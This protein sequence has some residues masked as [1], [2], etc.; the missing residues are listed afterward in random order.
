MD[1]TLKMEMLDKSG[2][3]WDVAPEPIHTESGIIIPNKMALVRSDNQTVL[4]IHGTGYDPYQNDELLELLHTIGGKVGLSLHTGGLFKGGA[5]VWFQLKSNDLKIGNDLIKGYISG[6]NS[7][8]GSSSLGFGN[9]SLTVSCANTFWRGY[10]EVDAHLRHSGQMR[11]KIET[12]L[13]QM[14]RLLV[15]EQDMFTEI[16]RLSETRMTP[17]IQKHVMET[18]LNLTVEERLD[19]SLLSTRKQ[20]MIKA[21]KYDLGIEVAQKQD[22]LWGLFSGVTR[23][24]THSMKKGNNSEGKMFGKTGRVERGIYNELAAM[25]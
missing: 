14:D 4:G 9:S 17:E 1:G 16:K 24:T 15:E 6:F 18:L 5:K 21:F 12:T 13:Q 3:N 10:K 23:Y 22:T 7:F 19:E 25:V 8:D 20:G 11:I 2:L